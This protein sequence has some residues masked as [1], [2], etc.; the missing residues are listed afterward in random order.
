MIQDDESKPGKKFS[1]QRITST[2]KKSYPFHFKR[3]KFAIRPAFA[4]TVN[5]GQGVLVI[6]VFGHRKAYVALSRVGDFDRI[7][8]LTP[9]GKPTSADV[10]FQ[11]VFDKDYIVTQIRPE[12]VR[13]IVLDR[14]DIDYGRMPDDFAIPYVDEETENLFEHMHQQD[15]YDSDDD[16]VEEQYDMDAHMYT[17]DETAFE[18]DWM[19]DDY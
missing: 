13:P 14:L 12:S 10:V 19:P 7:S 11:V 16:G 2:P 9:N 4:I 5:K 18:E 3:H 17:H 1:L 15:P 6:S 8:V